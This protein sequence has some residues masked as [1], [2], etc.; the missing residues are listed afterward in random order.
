ML[1]KQAEQILLAQMHRGKSPTAQVIDR[2]LGVVLLLA[3]FYCGA[4]WLTKQ[5][6]ISALL[7]VLLTAFVCSIVRMVQGNRREK[8]IRR[9]LQALEDTVRLEKLFFAR[10]EAFYR[11]LLPYL[12]RMGVQLSDDRKTAIWKGEHYPFHVLYVIPDCKVEE[13]D[14]LPLRGQEGIVFVTGDCTQAFLQFAKKL[15]FALVLTPCDEAFSKVIPIGQEEIYQYIVDHA[16]KKRKRSLAG[17]VV[18]SPKFTRRYVSCG[19]FLIF[20]SLFMLY[21][22]YYRIS[23]CVMFA[24]AAGCLVGRKNEVV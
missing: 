17:A 18:F 9:R 8:Y 2:V 16:P 3:L 23:A 22:L 11:M 5:T 19:V 21:P 13:R 6:F 10:R 12:E 14:L 15:G 7:A 4:H 20:S 1:Q 24:L